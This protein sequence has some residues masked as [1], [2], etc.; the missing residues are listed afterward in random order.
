VIGPDI[1]QE[2]DSLLAQTDF[3]SMVSGEGVS[4]ARKNRKAVNEEDWHPPFI[5]GANNLPNYKDNSGSFSRRTAVFPFRN[6]V[7]NRDTHLKDKILEREKVIILFR[8]L[9]R[10][11]LLREEIGDKE[12]ACRV[13]SDISNLRSNRHPTPWPSFSPTAASI[14]KF[15]TGRVRSRLSPRSTMLT[16]PG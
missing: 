9:V 5:M 2:L 13:S 4:V 6:L 11:M 7:Q 1:P 10:Y 3:Q 15:C 16:V 8:C 12:R 14:A